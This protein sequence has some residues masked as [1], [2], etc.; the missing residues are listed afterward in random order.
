MARVGAAGG[1]AVSP[2][3][4]L[5]GRGLGELGRLARA[6]PLMRIEEASV[7]CG[8]RPRVAAGAGD[9]Q[10]E[11]VQQEAQWRRHPWQ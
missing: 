5:R 9:E 8:G 2:G 4:L 1:G 10:E 7:A 3:P 6:L 11:E